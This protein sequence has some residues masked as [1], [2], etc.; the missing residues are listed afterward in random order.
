[1]QVPLYSK[2]AEVEASYPAH[3]EEELVSPQLIFFA[4]FKLLKMK[5]IK[6]TKIEFNA[7]VN[8]N[9]KSIKHAKL[10]KYKHVTQATFAQLEYMQSK[11][12]GF[13]RL[14]IPSLAFDIF[15]YLTTNFLAHRQKCIFA[16][17]QE[18]K[19]YERFIH[20]KN[21]TSNDIYEIINSID[22]EVSKIC[23]HI[24]FFTMKSQ[25]K[26][27]RGNHENK[28]CLNIIMAESINH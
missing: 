12:I 17:N 13:A 4:I 3:V 5:A 23:N 24:H 6:S 21:N 28:I 25:S 27:L 26:H 19:Q 11:N 8:I 14:C 15:K 1:M 22:E 2:V 18:I 7:H 10:K 9:K 20:A 16:S